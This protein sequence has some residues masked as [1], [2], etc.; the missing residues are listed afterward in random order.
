MKI[1]RFPHYRQ[2]D[3]MDCGPT[4]LRMIARFYGRHYTAQT[5]REKA[6]ISRDG[7]SLLGIADAAEQIGF[8]SVGVK[9]SMDKLIKEAPLPC[10]IHWGQHHFVV[11][12]KVDRKGFHVADPA[13]QVMTF[14]AEEFERHWLSSRTGGEREGIALLL[15]PTPSF[16]DEEGEKKRGMHIGQ[17][18]GYLWRY[19][20]LLLQLALGMLLGSGFQLLFPFLTQSVVDIGINTRN[21][22]FIY[23]VL[24]AQL[25]LMLG[26]SATGFLRSW[27]LLHISIRLNLAILSEFLAKLMRLPLSFFDVK[28]FGDI[29]QRIGDHQRIE[30][31][32]TGQTLS[33]AFS[34]L[35]LL[36]FGA[37]LAWYHFSIFIVAL[38]AGLVYALWVVGFLKKRRQLDSRRFTISA[39]NQSMIVQLIQGMQD[40]KLAG[41]EKLKR[42]DWEHLQARL[43]KWSMKSLSLSQFQEAGALL[44]NEGKNIFIT[45]LAAKA[46]VD[47]QLTL[48]GML[49]VQ[50]ILGQ[51]N[52]HR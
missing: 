51:F 3:Q 52:A 4:C 19:K 25:A 32:L 10:I 8:R 41:A 21:L 37:V 50:Y 6:Q 20:A 31:F 18:M 5:V 40:I 29:M 12:I 48:G 17:L 24:A 45:F 49:S 43:F 23:I 16:Y 34:L 42:W 47:G 38:V 35:N 22:S 14:T 11:L 39:L 28:Q 33:I 27:I 7:V 26:Q 46:V 30:S 44:I 9:M 13:R 2:L 36:V 15:E 1:T